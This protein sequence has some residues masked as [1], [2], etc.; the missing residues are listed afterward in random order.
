M[1]VD[2]DLGMKSKE[3]GIGD[4]FA[5][6]NALCQSSQLVCKGLRPS[7]LVCWTFDEVEILHGS[8][9]QRIDASDYEMVDCCNVAGSSKFFV[10]VGVVRLDIGGLTRL[11]WASP[12]DLLPG[13]RE[14]VWTW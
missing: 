9:G 4:F 11:V 12:S 1:A 6:N 14:V 2:G 3:D 8:T 13:W 5:L 7:L 10:R